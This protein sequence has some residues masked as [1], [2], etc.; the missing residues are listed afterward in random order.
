MRGRRWWRWRS[1]R[2]L[3]R[4]TTAVTT[5]VTTVATT[6]IDEIPRD[7]EFTN[8]EGIKMLEKTFTHVQTAIWAPGTFIHDRGK[9]TDPAARNLDL[10]KTFRPR[11]TAAILWSVQRD[12]H[13]TR[14]VVL[15][16]GT[17]SYGIVRGVATKPL[18]E[19]TRNLFMVALSCNKLGTKNSKNEGS[20]GF[21]SD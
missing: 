13:V 12:D 15:P 19:V 9:S 17:Q 3:W 6:A 14:I 5:T 21:H 1:R 7:G 4:V 11:R 10:F 20:N 16:T 8:A 2:C 18:L